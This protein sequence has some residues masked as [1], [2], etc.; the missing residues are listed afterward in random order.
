MVGKVNSAQLDILAKNYQAALEKGAGKA[1]K[2]FEV[3]LSR[4]N[5]SKRAI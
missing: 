5:R 3:E 2:R 1:P 4:K